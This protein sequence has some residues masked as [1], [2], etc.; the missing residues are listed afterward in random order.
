MR[1]VRVSA[2]FVIL[3]LFVIFPLLGCQK[4]THPA[5]FF[6]APGEVI[7]QIPVDEP[8]KPVAKKKKDKKH[9]DSKDLVISSP[10]LDEP[11]ESARNHTDP[12]LD[13][14]SSS[15][16]QADNG[17]SSETLPN[18]S[19]HSNLNH[20]ADSPSE[21]PVANTEASSDY[22]VLTPYDTN[23]PTLMGLSIRET[24]NVVVQ[25]FGKPASQYTMQD[26][27]DPISVY[28]Y[29]GFTIGFSKNNL[30]RFIDVSSSDI[31]PGLNGLR[32]GQKADDALK[33]IGKPNSNTDFVLNYVSGGNILKLDIDPKSKVIHSIKLFA[34]E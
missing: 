24:L 5:D 26:E 23:R 28:E 11:T 31:N 33:A 9:A 32:I 2:V 4:E 25:K 22:N 18:D 8:S 14:D 21:E 16:D 1:N 13:A 15:S 29:P 17:D 34:D 30:I 27:V 3:L 12:V 19:P 20:P 6:T 10:T 7:E